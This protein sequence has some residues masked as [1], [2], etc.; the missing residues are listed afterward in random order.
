MSGLIGIYNSNGEKFNTSSLG[1]FGMKLHIPSP[2]YEL[3]TESV[4][5]GG[6]IVLGKLLLPRD[7]TA[8]FFS[9]SSDYADSLKLRD[10]LYKIFSNGDEIYVDETFRTGKRWK[11]HVGE[12]MPERDNLRVQSFDIPLFAPSGLA[13][14][15]NKVRRVYNEAEFTFKNEGD[16]L[17]DMRKQ[18]ETTISFKGNSEGLTIK[19]LTTNEEWSYNGSTTAEDEIKLVGVQSLKNGQS[20]FGQT[21]KKILSL[22]A[23]NNKFEINGATGDFEIAISTYFYFL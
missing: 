22:A 5:D 16:V 8:E 11:V 10:E 3:I 23:G 1:L 6:E 12:W 13:E 17:I 2:S 21:N 20:I 18:T 9:Q 4:D 15:I 19:N 7:L 14:S